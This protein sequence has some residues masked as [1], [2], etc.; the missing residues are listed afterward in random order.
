MGFLSGIFSSVVKVT[1]TPVAIVKD[2]ANI[3]IG[4]E[5][6]TTKDLLESAADDVTE[7][8]ESIGE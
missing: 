5:P 2:A 3:V 8:I 7:A 6:D 4:E 1:L